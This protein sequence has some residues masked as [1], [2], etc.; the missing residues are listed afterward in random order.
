MPT[1]LEVLTEMRDLL[2]V[3]AEPA[4][5]KRDEKFRASLLAIVGRS[6]GRARAVL[7]MDG[8]RNQSAITKSSGL[9]QANISRLIKALRAQ[10]L[11]DTA[12]ELPKLLINVPSNF[13][14]STGNGH[15]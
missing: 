1:E 3:I 8:T 4:L 15:E 11:L 12:V 6:E 9:D 14:E 2:R 13:F 10:S 7:L 5:A